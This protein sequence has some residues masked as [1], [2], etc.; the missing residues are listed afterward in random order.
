M[1]ESQTTTVAAI[2]DGRSGPWVARFVVV[3]E[4]ERR[5]KFLD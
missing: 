4:E 2:L 3:V 1:I 5:E